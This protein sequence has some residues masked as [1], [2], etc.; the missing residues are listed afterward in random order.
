[1]ACQDQVYDPLIEILLYVLNMALGKTILASRIISQLRARADSS[2]TTCLYFYFKHSDNSKTTMSQMLRSMLVQLIHQDNTLF[3]A[4]YSKCSVVSKDETQQVATLQ[5]WATD[6]LR[7]QGSCTIILDGLDECKYS[8]DGNEGQNILEWFLSSIIPECFNEG[9]V[10]RLLALGQ[11]DGKI[12]EILSPYPSI[13]LDSMTSHID[14]IRGFAQARASQLADRFSLDAIEEANV[15][16]KVTD[17][18]KG[19]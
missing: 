10:I 8:K 2:C 1:M 16:Q 15:T 17:A 3:E 11:R 12:D 4:L 7:T 18:A 9:G 13:R 5:A 19:Q 6:L 14:D